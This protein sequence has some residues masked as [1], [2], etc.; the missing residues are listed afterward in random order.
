MWLRSA[1]VHLENIRISAG[2]QACGHKAATDLVMLQFAKLTLERHVLVGVQENLRQLCVFKLANES[3]QPWQW[4][5]Y[6]TKF[7]GVCLTH[8]VR[9]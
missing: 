2:Q 6:V 9:L 7:A 4:W 5:T 1:T 3:G 8:G